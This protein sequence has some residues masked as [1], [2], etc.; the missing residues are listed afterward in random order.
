MLQTMSWKMSKC[1][2]LVPVWVCEC[3][4]SAST[5]A[6]RDNDGWVVS[7]HAVPPTS[8]HGQIQAASLL[9]S[10]WPPPYLLVGQ[11]QGDAVT[12]GML[13]LLPLPKDGSSRDSLGD[14]LQ[15]PSQ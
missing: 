7:L 15:G 12:K 1:G 2:E 3:W 6:A 13:F 9:H 4:S 5:H 14:I 10:H 8:S 11:C